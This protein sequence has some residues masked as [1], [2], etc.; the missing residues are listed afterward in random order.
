E[1]IEKVRAASLDLILITGDYVDSKRNHLPALPN[2]KKLLRSLTSRLGTYGILGNHDG[3]KLAGR[4][5]NEPIHLLDNQRLFL[6]TR[7]GKLELIGLAGINRK[8]LN[9]D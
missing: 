5:F 7:N 9:P 8:K 6:D 2:V 4:I 1:L 3:M